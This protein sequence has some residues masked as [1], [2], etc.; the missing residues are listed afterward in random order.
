[1]H[2]PSRRHARPTPKPIT[3]PVT[4]P[5][6][7]TPPG[8][9]PPPAP[10]GAFATAMAT[11]G[12]WLAGNQLADGAILYTSGQIEAY[13]GNI[14]ATGWLK[15]PGSLPAVR[16][17]MAWYVAHMNVTDVW[18]LGGTM[19]DYSLSGTKETSLKTADSVDSYCATFLTLARQLYDTK[20]AT[21]VA[22]VTS[23]KSTLEE[24]GNV[25]LKIQQPDGLTIAT[26][27]YTEAYLEDNCE[28]WRGLTD[29][30]YLETALG[31]AVGAATYKSAA[32]KVASGIAGMWDANLGAYGWARDEVPA[33]PL[34]LPDLTV[35]YPDAV[36]QLFPVLHGVLAPTDPRAVALYATFCKNWPTWQNL[37]AAGANV[38]PTFDPWVCIADAAAIMGDTTRANAFIAAV[39]SKFAPSFPWP[40]YDMESGWY[41]R[42]LNQLALG[43]SLP[44]SNN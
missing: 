31:N 10:T 28:V 37:T 8:T 38:P 12:K 25:L 6:V 9:T 1:M 36:S 17:W 23:L 22:Y 21:S 15:V 5:P 7:T 40:W 4:T 26:P 2:N 32:A 35:W 44:V 42:M 16:A 19:Y 34:S 33:G 27:S 29:L 11:Q 14:A 30:A 20:D 24:I 18:G 43:S 41:I 39:N 13:Y 3:P